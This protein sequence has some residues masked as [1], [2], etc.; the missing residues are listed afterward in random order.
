MDNAI[1]WHFLNI[2]RV[3][4]SYQGDFLGLSSL[5]IWFWI[6]FVVKSL[7]VYSGSWRA[8]LISVSRSRFMAVYLV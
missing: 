2:F 8:L 5:C 6:I 4:G 3:I 1:P 7:I